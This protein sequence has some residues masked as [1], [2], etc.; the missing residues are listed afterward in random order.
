MTRNNKIK[1]LA[2]LGLLSAVLFIMSYTP[3][4]YLKVG[5]LAITFNV[6][7]VA[8]AA[9]ALGPKGGAVIG[10]VFGLTSFL[11][12][13]AGGSA[14]GAA[15][16]AISPVLTA[17][18][19]FAP[20]ILDGLVCGFIADIFKKKNV[21]GAI[22]GAVTGFAAAFLNTLFFMTSL[23]VL[24]GKSEYVQGLR[25]TVAEGKNVVVF[26]ILLVGI[27]AVAEWGAS[28]L[29]SSAVSAALKAAKLI[30]MPKKAE[31]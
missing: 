10:G 11:Q 2:I 4:G 28:T 30:D 13:V 19:C 23:M 14:M 6:I 26:V 3:L 31:A 16:M 20:R 29:A 5:V 27:N 18:Q 9:Y 15:M 24:F 1:D 7:P 17:V 22:A 21:N 25:T 8:I 12:A